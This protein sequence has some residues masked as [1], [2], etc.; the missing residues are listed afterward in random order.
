MIFLACVGLLFLMAMGLQRLTPNPLPLSQAIDLETHGLANEARR[1]FAVVPSAALIALTVLTVG[2]SVAWNRLQEPE[3]IVPERQS[4]MMFPRSFG[5]WYGDFTRLDPAVETVLGADDYV[6]ATYRNSLD[7][8]TFQFFSAYYQDQTNGG[9]LHSPE[10]CLP[11]GGW[12][13]YSLA[14]YQ[15]DMTDVGYGVFELNRAVIQKGMHN[16]LVYYWFEQ[17]GKRMTNDFLTKLSVLK[18]AWTIH[19][20]DGAIVR[21]V[22][23]IENGDEAEADRRLQAI[24]KDVLVPLP[25]FLPE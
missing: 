15:V 5:S 17:R 10:V 13:V 8:S 3:I 2:V 25:R 14:P 24:M 23:D 7:G 19:R 18:D 20:K 12:E 22:I 16:Q 11:N 4:Y 1:I 21:F 6:A 9:G